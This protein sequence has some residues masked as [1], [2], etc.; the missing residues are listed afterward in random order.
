MFEREP[1]VSLRQVYYETRI[2]KDNSQRKIIRL[3][4][5]YLLFSKKDI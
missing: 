1:I 4:K 3:E 2:M 5:S